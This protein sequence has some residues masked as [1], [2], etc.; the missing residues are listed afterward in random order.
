MIQENL[1]AKGKLHLVL[2][3]KDG[4]IILER[5]ETNLVVSVG[6]AF[7]TSRMLGTS[8]TVMSHMAIGTTNTAA[9]AGQTA[10]LAEVGRV[11]LTSSAQQTVT[12]TNDSVSFVATFG[13]GV[14]TGT[15]VEAGVLNNSSGG[16]MLCRSVF[17]AITKGAGDS[18]TITWTVTLQ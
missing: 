6:K 15:I 5:E 3:D 8:S 2:R 11:A 10:L 16:T 1:S 14:G 12:S 13:A 17:G 9:A 7:I 18:L 4:N